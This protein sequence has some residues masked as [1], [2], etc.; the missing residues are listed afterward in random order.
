VY[1]VNDTTAA[2]SGV[3]ADYYTARFTTT[4]NASSACTINL[5]RGSDD[6]IRVKVN[7]N[8]VIDDWDAYAY[9]T[10]THNNIPIVAG[11]NTIVVEYYEQTGQSGYSL[12]WQS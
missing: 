1:K 8:T 3:A 11:A 5:R 2:P 9:K 12:E 7:G 6:G 4:I 10:T